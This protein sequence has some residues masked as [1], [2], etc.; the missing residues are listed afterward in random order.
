MLSRVYLFAWNLLFVL[1]VVVCFSCIVDV[2]LLFCVVFMVESN[3]AA[4]SSVAG[5]NGIG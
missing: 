1:C 3:K 5:T 2:C 4:C